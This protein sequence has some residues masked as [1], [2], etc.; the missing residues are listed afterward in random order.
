VLPV[1]SELV[2]SELVVSEAL[3]GAV[4]EPEA[5]VEPA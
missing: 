4:S 1:V 2:V 3:W 5:V